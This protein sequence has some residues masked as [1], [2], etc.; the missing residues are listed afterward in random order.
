MIDFD[1][2][3]YKHRF[4]RLKLAPKGYT[5]PVWL[6]DVCPGLDL[7]KIEKNP[8]TANIQ[9]QSISGHKHNVSIGTDQGQTLEI[10][11]SSGKIKGLK[12]KSPYDE[13]FYGLGM[14]FRAFGKKRGVFYLKNSESPYILQ[15]FLTYSSMPILLSNHS[16]AIFLLN[17]HPTI[18]RLNG[19]SGK[20]S[21]TWKDGAADIILFW[22]KH[23]KEIISN[24]TLICGRPEIPP[25][26]AFGLWHTSYPVEDQEKTLSYLKRFRAH[27]IPL[28]VEILDYHWEE[29]FHNFKWSKKY[30]PR[31]KAFIDTLHE[32][33]LKL[34][35]I[36]TPFI[37]KKDNYSTRL[38]NHLIVGRNFPED[39]SYMTNLSDKAL[40]R[41]A[42]AHNYFIHP[43]VSWWFGKGGMIDFTSKVAADFWFN[44]S[45]P[46]LDNGVDF[47]KN[48]DGEYL[49]KAAKSAIGLDSNEHHNTY[50]FYYS[51]AIYERLEDYLK[52]R[53]LVYA[54]CV[55]IGSQRYPGIFLGDQK[56]TFEGMQRSLN[57]GLNLSMLGFSYWG[58]DI[59]GLSGEPNKDVHKRYI[60]YAIFTPIARYFSSPFAKKRDPWAWGS[61]NEDNFRIYVQLRYMLLPHLYSY[62]YIA[63]TTGIPIVRPVVLEY[64]NEKESSAISNQFFIG[65]EVMVAPYINNLD[66]REIYLPEGQWIDVR[67]LHIITGSKSIEYSSDQLPVFVKHGA[68]LALS[69]P[70]SPIQVN[71]YTNPVE[72]Y[73]FLKD[74]YTYL[75]YDDDGISLN[76]KDEGFCLQRI[77]YKNTNDYIELS[78]KKQ[79]GSMDINRDYKITLFFINKFSSIESNVRDIIY[80]YDKAN[81]ILELRFKLFSST[82]AEIRISKV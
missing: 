23:L 46:L 22:G 33:G 6:N 19:A 73:C 45:R 62:A 20:V 30:F 65:K 55:W 17:A 52:H 60:Q 11:L 18:W 68:I 58:A 15:R 54:R 13:T 10:S 26:W 76:Y 40:Y 5:G 44:L 51:K 64:S 67:D 21:I 8:C 49:P 66:K 47:F 25:R 4:V 63:Y 57:A 34:G 27:G 31:P 69:R 48:D 7:Y 37:N 53:A 70:S 56:A 2:T 14:D 75:L 29:K 50:G 74:E 82:P 32:I 35:L 61:K 12:I 79:S 43:N 80:N 3:H 16:W 24:I 59:Y 72:I 1:L 42:R 77:Y 38:R 81:T 41:I 71:S 36:Y 9:I 78:I 39:L 28:D